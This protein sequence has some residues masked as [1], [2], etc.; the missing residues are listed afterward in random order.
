MPS[1]NTKRP[2]SASVPIISSL[3]SRTFPVSVSATLAIF[4]FKLIG[5]VQ[6]WQST[7]YSRPT[8][9][10]SCGHVGPRVEPRI[11]ILGEHAVD[12]ALDAGWQIRPEGSQR[13]MRRLGNLLSQPGPRVGGGRDVAS[14]QLKLAKT[15]RKKAPMTFRRSPL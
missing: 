6:S 12:D 14:Q 5:F 11:G 1:A 3:C 10:Q 13:R 7:R 9:V 15:Q 4:P 8:V 2:M